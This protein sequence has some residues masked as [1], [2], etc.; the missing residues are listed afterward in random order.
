MNSSPPI[1]VRDGTPYVVFREQEEWGIR[2]FDLAHPP[3]RFWAEQETSHPAIEPGV[4]AARVRPLSTP[5]ELISALPEADTWSAQ[6][7][8]SLARLFAHY[9]ICEDPQ[10][11]LDAREVITLSHQVSLVRHVL[12]HEHLRRVMIADEVGRSAH[13]RIAGH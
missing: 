5:A 9:L 12:D 2:T 6:S 7:K 11:R 4:D 13:S 3:R 8:R 1:V 10:R